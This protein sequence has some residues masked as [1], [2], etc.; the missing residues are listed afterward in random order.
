[1]RTST[2]LNHIQVLELSYLL[3]PQGLHRNYFLRLDPYNNLTVWIII[4]K[5]NALVYVH[6][7]STWQTEAG[8]PVSK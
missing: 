7:T 5:K 6:N 8:S 1:M 3:L 2:I 4:H